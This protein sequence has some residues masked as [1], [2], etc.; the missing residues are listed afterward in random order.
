VKLKAQEVDAVW[1]TP[2]QMWKASSKAGGSEMSLDNFFEFT[3]HRRLSG[4]VAFFFM[5][6]IRRVRSL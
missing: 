5:V 1:K 4:T 2:P 6:R 3:F